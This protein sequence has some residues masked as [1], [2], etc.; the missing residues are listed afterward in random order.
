[1]SKLSLDTGFQVVQQTVTSRI[2][3][4]FSAYEAVEG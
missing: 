4:G 3:N 2:V 1:L